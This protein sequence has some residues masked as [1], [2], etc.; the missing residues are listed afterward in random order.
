MASMELPERLTADRI[1]IRLHEPKDLAAFTM[2]LQDPAA[3]EFLLFEPQQRTADGA[4]QMLE[5]VIDSYQSNDPIK[6]FTIADIRSDEYVGSCGL[7]ILGDETAE[8]YYTILPENQSSGLAT[9]AVS[10][11]LE[12]TFQNSDIHKIVAHV[13]LENHASVRVAEKLGFVDAGQVENQ[14]QSSQV[15][16]R[17]F[18]GHRYVLER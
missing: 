4:K 8:V 1:V 18:Q 11:L 12:W 5:A 7:N 10:R 6:S 15:P 17:A 16:N 13:F 14:P 9:E 2:F 3:T